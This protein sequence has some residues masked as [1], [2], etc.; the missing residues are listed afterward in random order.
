M[1]FYNCAVY[2]FLWKTD[3]C[4]WKLSVCPYYKSFKI[5]DFCAANTKN[6]KKKFKKNLSISFLTLSNCT[7]CTECC[8][9]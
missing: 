3:F 1:L 2:W 8:I 9:V 6:H 5:C 7:D 4:E